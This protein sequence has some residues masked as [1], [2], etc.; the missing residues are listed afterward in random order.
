[1]A[2]L[3][4][5]GLRRAV[6][7]VPEPAHRAVRA[8]EKGLLAEARGEVFLARLLREYML[9]QARIRLLEPRQPAADQQRRPHAVE[10]HA[11]SGAHGQRASASS[12]RRAT[13]THGA[14]A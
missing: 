5:E 9:D 4:Q 2:V 12:T 1:D 7:L 13:R 3:A 6:D 14:R 10:H 8:R 11:R